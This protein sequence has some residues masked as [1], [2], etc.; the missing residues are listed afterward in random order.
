[1]NSR[2]NFCLF[3]AVLIPASGQTLSPQLLHA[4]NSVL[5]E[6]WVVEMRQDSFSA[7]RE[8]AEAI[9]VALD[10]G[11]ARRDE[12]R[13]T[14]L[15]VPGTYLFDYRPSSGPI[16]PAQ[17]WTVRN[18]LKLSP[19]VLN[20]DPEFIYLTPEAQDDLAERPGTT[21][22][23]WKTNTKRRVDL[24]RSQSSNDDDA[25]LPGSEGKF[26]WNHDAI[27][28][29]AA[30]NVTAPNKG[31]TDGTGILIG[32]PDT[33]YTRHPEYFPARIRADLGRN[34][35]FT[36]DN[37]DA[38]DPLSVNIWDRLAYPLP[39]YFHGHGTRI[40]SSLIAPVGPREPGQ[41]PFASGV[42]P[43]AQTIP[44]RVAPSVVIFSQHRLARAI[45]HAVDKGAH[46]ISISLGGL[47][48]FLLDR[49]VEY[50]FY[51]NVIVCAAAGNN[52]GFVT[53]PGSSEFAIGVAATNFY[54]EAWK[55]SCRG[56]E[57]DI[58]AP[59]EK[60]YRVD[61]DSV[62]DNGNVTE[63][64]IALGSGTSFAVT[65]VAGVAAM[66]LSYHG[67]ENLRRIYPEAGMIPR[68]YKHII[69]KTA[70]LVT[71]TRPRAQGEAKPIDWGRGEFG[72]G[73]LDAEAV[74]K[75]PLPKAS[76]LPPF[77]P[78]KTSAEDQMGTF[79]AKSGKIDRANQLAKAFGSTRAVDL[80]HLHP[81]ELR[82]LI[83]TSRAARNQLLDPAAERAAPLRQGLSEQAREVLK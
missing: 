20:V 16:A 15:D 44:I 31:P 26:E 53:A 78:F 48:S 40:A 3:L 76:D 13:D 17:A 35:W 46:V 45:R 65:H 36:G 72:A 18:R 47:D 83:I 68:V 71:S 58:S 64:A 73:L 59:G 8:V 37:D 2:F 49:A 77:E 25:P 43:G 4:D 80:T 66:W 57:V 9:A 34:V 30:R 74:M 50:A 51:R 42:A 1:M 69:T 23:D 41:K 56:R 79:I 7:R 19:R 61:V 10:L 28:L 60:I 32:H 11:A 14:P 67:P 21:P 55:S 62:D 38:S 27:N 39:L 29:G 70:R 75:E 22:L 5:F 33:G 12:I 81:D 82:F 54:N 6:G 24:L 63:K 52:V